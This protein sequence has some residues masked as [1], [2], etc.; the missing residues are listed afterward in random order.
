MDYI[1]KD[2]FG[3]PKKLDWE[4]DGK[5]GPLKIGVDIVFKFYKFTYICI[6]HSCRYT[7]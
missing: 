3:A 2:L 4:G 5:Q 1:F 6:R 7:S